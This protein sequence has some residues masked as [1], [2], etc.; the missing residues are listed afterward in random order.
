MWR[1]RQEISVCASQSFEES[2]GEVA[3]EEARGQER[4]MTLS[5][6]Y[7]SLGQ[8]WYGEPHLCCL[9]WETLKSK[10]ISRN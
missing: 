10:S 4:V 6:V 1:W 7:S 9:L 5:Q 2:E 3:A 8:A